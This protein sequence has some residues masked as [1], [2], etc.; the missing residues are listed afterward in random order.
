MKTWIVGLGAIL[1]L[2]GVAV[3]VSDSPLDAIK[4][5]GKVSPSMIDLRGTSPDVFNYS[6]FQEPNSIKDNH[7]GLIEWEDI[8]QR[9]DY[10]QVPWSLRDMLDYDKPL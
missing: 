8:M 6:Q 3:A 1:F 10:T 2:I 7:R 9:I 5:A 4:D